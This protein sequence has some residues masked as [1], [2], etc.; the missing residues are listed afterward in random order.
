MA[1][2]VGPQAA[3]SYMPMATYAG[4]SAPYFI[5]NGG[6]AVISN[7]VVTDLS[8]TDVTI[9]D[10]L[11][12]S[13]LGSATG[14]LEMTSAEN[15]FINSNGTGDVF[16]S[17]RS[18]AGNVA[19]NG[20]LGA[21]GNIVSSGGGILA[22]VGPIV[23]GSV[24]TPGQ[25][26]VA[27]SKGSTLAEVS[28]VGPTRGLYMYS[29]N[30]PGPVQDASIYYGNL[31]VDGGINQAPSMIWSDGQFVLQDTLSANLI[32]ATNGNLS[33]LGVPMSTPSITTI[34]DQTTGL[35]PPYAVASVGTAVPIVSNLP[36]TAGRIY[37]I[38]IIAMLNTNGVTPST[39]A[40]MYIDMNFNAGYTTPI[41]F[42]QSIEDTPI[43]GGYSVT[44]KAPAGATSFNINVR[45]GG[46]VSDNI[47]GSILN[48]FYQVIG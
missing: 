36:V 28:V 38:D 13:T 8:A 16:I 33:I 35:S 12:V 43:I 24:G 3:S 40:F 32:T 22:T 6:N 42:V 30:L 48:G 4:K 44:V 9:S 37:R 1:F 29:Q 17:A 11:T 25:T 31:P 27:L 14:D 46:S 19:I 26:G 41:F 34:Y 39:T 23:A 7:L 18:G 21:S 5:P 10:A 2:P 47:Y 15:V 45:A 20:A